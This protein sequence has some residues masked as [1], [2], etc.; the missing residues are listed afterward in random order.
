MSN[1]PYATAYRHKKQVMLFKFMT[2]QRTNKLLEQYNHRLNRVHR[3]AQCITLW[4][5]VML[6]K[7]INNYLFTNNI[8]YINIQILTK[9][10]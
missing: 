8:F 4:Y 9:K 7:Y 1:K 2:L 3:N 6:Y 10:F 5:N